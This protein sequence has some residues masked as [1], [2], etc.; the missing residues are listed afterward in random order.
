MLNEHSVGTV[1]SRRFGE[2]F[3][4]PCS[5]ERLSF[6]ELVPSVRALFSGRRDDRCLAESCF[7]SSLKRYDNVLLLMLDAFGWSTFQRF[8]GTHP[9]LTTL[10]NEG[11]VSLLTSMFPSTTTAH[12]TYA[13][14]GVTPALS[15]LYEW[16]VHV[17]E[18]GLIIPL[19]FQRSGSGEKDGLL[20]ESARVEDVFPAQ[21]LFGDLAATGIASAVFG[22]PEVCSSAVTRY[23]ARDATIRPCG[24]LDLL[25]QSVLE[26]C[27][28]RG[29]Y[30]YVYI[31]DIDRAAHAH[32]PG[33]HEHDRTVRMVLDTA[34]EIVRGARNRQTAI[35]V[36][37]DHG[38]IAIVP[39]EIVWI[40]AARP[41]ILPLLVRDRRTGGPLA[42]GGGIRDLFLHV[43]PDHV[44]AAV[45]LL[46]EELAG[47][48]EIWRT[49]DLVA[50][51]VFGSD[52]PGPLFD[53]RV[54]NVVILPT[55]SRSVGWSAHKPRHPDYG[56]HGGLTP[57]EMRIPFGLLS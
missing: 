50:R 7:G 38:H 19:R 14:T 35:I 57:D 27:K 1:T 16:R 20:A 28:E 4:A 30:F 55:G 11:T 8:R 3:Q 23:L 33:S 18:L 48:A 40:D 46:E 17:P 13:L 32:G 10:E 44:D 41:D 29:W 47:T 2:H 6:A 45:R 42:A 49:S 37:A 31:D 52:T 24:S 34:W 22:P 9:L 39:D 5:T 15:G 54:G 53:A 51:G 36:I 12:V 43:V 56:F 25:A 26:S 21:S